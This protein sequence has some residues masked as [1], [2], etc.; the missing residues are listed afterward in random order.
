MSYCLKVPKTFIP[1]Y[2]ANQRAKLAYPRKDG[3]ELKQIE[4]EEEFDEELKS[5]IYVT[6][7]NQ[8]AVKNRFSGLYDIQ[9]LIEAQGE[10]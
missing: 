9:V 5:A 7:S 2:L 10:I 3:E 1:S 4:K 8:V 6:R